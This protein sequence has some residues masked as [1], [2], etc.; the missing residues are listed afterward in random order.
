MRVADFVRSCQ[1]R[2]TRKFRLQAKLRWR[3]FLDQVR[4]FDS[5]GSISMEKKLNFS[6]SELFLFSLLTNLDTGEPSPLLSF[7]KSALMGYANRGNPSICYRQY[8]KC[9]RSNAE[10]VNYL[11]NHNGGFFRFFGNVRGSGYPGSYY[12]GAP[13][14]QPAPPP[15]I[16]GPESDRTGTGELKF[17]SATGSLGREFMKSFFP[18]RR[19]YNNTDKVIFPQEPLQ[20]AHSLNRVS[21]SLTSYADPGNEYQNAASFFPQV[22]RFRGLITSS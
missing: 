1:W 12:R 17:D 21:K 11:N 15:G 18:E 5:L 20:G 22:R 4:R 3:Q 7:G 6:Y 10:L 2:H 8:P 13:R 14:R 19:E 9:P 16:S